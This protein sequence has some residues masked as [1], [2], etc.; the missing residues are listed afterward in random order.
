MDRVGNFSSSSIWRLMTNGRGENGVGKPFAEYVKEKV[1]ENRLDRQ[2]QNDSYSKSTQWGIF[3]ERFAFDR[4]PLE[5]KLDSQ[6]RYF[7]P[8]YKHFCGAP[9]GLDTKDIVYDIKCPYSMKSFCDLLESFES[10]ERFKKE[11]PSYYWQL[12]ANGILTSRNVAQLIVFV[13]NE[14]DLEEIQLEAADFDGADQWK[15]RFIY[16][17]NKEELPNITEGGYYKNITSFTFE[18]PVEDEQ[19]LLERVALASSELEKQLA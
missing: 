17:A 11:Y 10:L 5:Y 1:Y 15:V 4:L 12:V 16:E 2:L 6:K 14:T 7:H 13:P 9:D 8:K 18:I 19:L 3:C